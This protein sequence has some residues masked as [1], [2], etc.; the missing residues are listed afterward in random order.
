MEQQLCLILV[1][2]VCDGNLVQLERTRSQNISKSTLTLHNAES[3]PAL[4]LDKNGAQYVVLKRVKT[5]QDSSLSYFVNRHGIQWIPTCIDEFGDSLM[6]K[7]G[8]HNKRLGNHQIPDKI[9]NFASHLYKGCYDIASFTG[10][11][12]YDEGLPETKGT[13]EGLRPVGTVAGENEV[14][15][16]FGSL[17]QTVSSV[18]KAAESEV[19]ARFDFNI[20]E[21]NYNVDIK[22][23]RKVPPNQFYWKWHEI[24]TM[25]ENVF[26][27][28]V[29]DFFNPLESVNFKD[30]KEA[31]MG[32]GLMRYSKAKLAGKSSTEAF[33]EAAKYSGHDLNDSRWRAKTEAKYYFPTSAAKA[34]CPG[35]ELKQVQKPLSCMTR[36][37]KR[38]LTQSTNNS[39]LNFFK[40]RTCVRKTP[41]KESIINSSYSL[42]KNLTAV[43][44]DVMEESFAEVSASLTLE[45]R[46]ASVTSQVAKVY[47]LKAVQSP[48]RT[49][50]SPKSYQPLKLM[51]DQLV[52]T[53]LVKKASVIDKPRSSTVRKAP[54]SFSRKNKYKQ[55]PESYPLNRKMLMP[56]QDGFNK[57]T[58]DKA[59]KYLSA[60]EKWQKMTKDCVYAVPK[61]VK[62]KCLKAKMHALR[63]VFEN[64][65]L[66]SFVYNHTD[67]SFRFKRSSSR[68]H[69]HDNNGMRHS[70]ESDIYSMEIRESNE[71][72]LTL[73]DK[74]PLYITLH[75]HIKIIKTPY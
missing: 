13:Y 47:N 6:F 18:R 46:I 35:T 10:N 45:T 24:N 66:I 42:A 57:I 60:L 1:E 52:K 28:R 59:R 39:V 8:L 11:L 38:K 67:D 72:P 20:L 54:A 44:S 68:Y 63:I 36:P 73:L 56:R 26:G 12:Y 27:T 61:G 16:K 65:Q 7:P 29:W 30:H 25:V 62:G 34:I 33:T 23:G 51:N 15:A 21:Q 5:L 31:L 3:D 75:S 48:R 14:E 2:R 53:F 50:A 40:K 9:L 58:D 70:A 37:A 4:Y 32:F 74:S 69:F 41:S 22:V 49:Q 64:N 71:A 17:V 55:K 19:E 43:D